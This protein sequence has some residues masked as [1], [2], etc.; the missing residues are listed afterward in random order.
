MKNG[1]V[2]IAA[3]L[4]FLLMHCEIIRIELLGKNI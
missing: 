3:K 1:I 2:N 4:S